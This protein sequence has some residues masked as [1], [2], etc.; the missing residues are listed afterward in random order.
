MGHFQPKSGIGIYEPERI[1]SS[2][3]Y[4]SRIVICITVRKN[5]SFKGVLGDFGLVFESPNLLNR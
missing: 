3:F 4:F 5:D 1:R 2:V